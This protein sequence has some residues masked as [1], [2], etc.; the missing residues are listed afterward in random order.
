VP[1]QVGFRTKPQLARVMLERALDAG[2]PAAWVTADEVYGGSPTLRQ[3]LEGRGVWHV[4]AVKCTE[5]L[6]VASPNGVVRESAEQLGAAVP[7]EQW[8]AC[9]AGHGAKGRRL[10][11]WTRVELAAP[12]TAGMAGWLLVRRSHSDGELAFYACYGPAATPLVGLVRVAGTRWAVE[13]GFEQAKGEVGLDHY[14]VRKWPGWYR[15]ITLALLAH[16]FLAGTRAQATTSNGRKGGPGGLTGGL[17]LLPLTVP[18]V[19]RLLVALV[20]TAPV[21]PGLVLAWSRWRRRHQA[22]AR[23]AHDQ[24]RERQVG[25]SGTGAVPYA[26]RFQSPPVK[27]CVRFSR[28]RL[29]DVLHRRRSTRQSR[30]GLGEVTAPSRLIR[31]RW[32]GDRSTW[33]MPQSQDRRRLPVL[34]NSNATL[35]RA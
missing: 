25:G 34:D 31:P 23:R 7:A 3:W 13:E 24:R 17:G 35:R 30:K 32:L 33:R 9:S 8:I 18:E 15:H 29:T 1:E 21:Q 16:A 20:W 27:P 28:T 2:V 26:V 19:R 5:L 12:A 4:L 22:R 6:E 10:Y 11:D 14:Q